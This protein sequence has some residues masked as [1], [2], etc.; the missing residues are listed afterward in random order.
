M[1]FRGWPGSTS[2]TGRRQTGKVFT[3]SSYICHKDETLPSALKVYGLIFGSRGAINNV[4]YNLLIAF[5]MTKS[6]IASKLDFIFK[7]S[8]SIYRMYRF[9]QWLTYWRNL[10]EF[11]CYCLFLLFVGPVGV[12]HSQFVNKLLES[13]IDFLSHENCCFIR[14][15]TVTG[16]KTEHH[17]F[18]DKTLGRSE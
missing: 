5:G 18:V 8:L 14:C 17:D 6:R 13:R 11:Y 3:S 1:F 2:R 16:Y 7:D 9:P 10:Y 4:T 15:W 12:V